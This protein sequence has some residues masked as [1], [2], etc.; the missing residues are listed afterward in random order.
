MMFC[1]ST[2]RVSCEPR[3]AFV[4]P[5]PALHEFIQWFGWNLVCQRVPESTRPFRSGALIHFCGVRS[6]ADNC[7]KRL[8]V[9]GWLDIPQPQ[10]LEG[11]FQHGFQLPTTPPD[12]KRRSDRNRLHPARG[13]PGI[14]PRRF[15]PAGDLAV[16][17]GWCMA[18]HRKRV[19]SAEKKSA[20]NMRVVPRGMSL[21]KISVSRRI[22]SRSP[23]ATANHREHHAP[24]RRACPETADWLSR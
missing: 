10:R 18:R 24:H 20:K 7:S 16:M 14:H 21:L 3:C 8:V 1:A 23:K 13:W 11:S 17:L 2:D 12:R 4:D 19:L 9:I 22:L 5:T 6:A 15:V